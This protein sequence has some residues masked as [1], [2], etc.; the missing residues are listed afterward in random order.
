[1]KQNI[2]EIKRMQQLAGVIKESQLDE[3]NDYTGNLGRANNEEVAK[4]MPSLQQLVGNDIKAIINKIE[5]EIKAK[6]IEDTDTRNIATAIGS[7]A[8]TTMG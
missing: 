1:M 8:Y 2:N 6:K 7:I 5:A 3:G 4:I